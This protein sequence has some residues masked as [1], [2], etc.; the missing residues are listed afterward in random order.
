[1]EMV[2]LNNQRQDV[3]L[4]GSMV[5]W[6]RR[7]CQRV[8]HDMSKVRSVCRDWEFVEEDYVEGE[9]EVAHP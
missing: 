8:Q 3:V 5:L 1:M 7:N 4:V 6:T 9:R 2:L